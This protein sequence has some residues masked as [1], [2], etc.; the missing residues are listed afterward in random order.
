M[1]LAGSGGPALRVSRGVV[2]A[3]ALANI[4]T[5]LGVW[6]SK[7]WVSALIMSRPTAKVPTVV[8]RV[9]VTSWAPDLPS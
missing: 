2:K 9:L 5:F 1:G 6:Q 4:F 8:V 3:A 7:F